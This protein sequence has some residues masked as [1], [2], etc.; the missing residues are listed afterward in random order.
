M[1]WTRHLR[2]ACTSQ[3]QLSFP[4]QASLLLDLHLTYT[5]YPKLFLPYSWIL[6]KDSVWQRLIFAWYFFFFFEGVGMEISRKSY[7]NR[8]FTKS[9]Q[10][11]WVRFMARAMTHCQHTTVG[12]ILRVHSPPL[13]RGPD[14]FHWGIYPLSCP[15]HAELNPSSRGESRLAEHSPIFLAPVMVQSWTQALI[16]AL[17]AKPRM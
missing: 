1:P 4:S 5:V 12:C 17:E 15:R 2:K 11:Y 7:E 8:T 14:F 10:V 13:L 3:I 6:C 16:W 9:I